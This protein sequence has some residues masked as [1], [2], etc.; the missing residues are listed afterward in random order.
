MA[1]ALRRRRRAESFEIHEDIPS[2]EDTEVNEDA[3][4]AREQHVVEQEDQERGE[5]EEDLSESSDDE[6]MDQ[7][8]QQDMERLQNTF[9]GFR[10]QF[11]LIKR[12]GEGRMATVVPLL[13][14]G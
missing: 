10:H 5:Q 7:G 9:P 13:P 1:S 8:V 11:R 6:A 2:T 12:I 14:C 4:P 3:V